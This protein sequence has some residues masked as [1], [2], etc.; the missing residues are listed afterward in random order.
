MPVTL[1]TTNNHASL[2]DSSLINQGIFVSFD[3]SYD[4]YDDDDDDYY[5]V[6]VEEV[7]EVVFFNNI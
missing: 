2:L 5:Y 4:Y 6:V 3:S 1:T 7:V